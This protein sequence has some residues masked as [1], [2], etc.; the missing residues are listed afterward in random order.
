MECEEC[1]EENSEELERKLSPVLD[2]ERIES[3]GL[4]APDE[5]DEGCRWLGMDGCDLTDAPS[6][7][8]DMRFPGA[9]CR[10][11][12]EDIVSDRISIGSALS[13]VTDTR[14][15]GA[16]CSEVRGD[17]DRISTGCTLSVVIEMRFPDVLRSGVR[18]KIVSDPKST[19]SMLGASIAYGEGGP[20]VDMPSTR[21]L[22]LVPSDG[23]PSPT[24]T[25]MIWVQRR[26]WLSEYC[27][28]RW[29]SELWELIPG[30]DIKRG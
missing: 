8:S 1:C 7:V 30:I 20:M 10:E 6:Y 19:G 25:L 26:R 2:T 13:E 29:E 24:I 16:L 4:D 5:A 11:V 9:L 15:L 3:P 21:S 14:F 23:E 28:F 27:L 12:R 22:L 17:I 18:G